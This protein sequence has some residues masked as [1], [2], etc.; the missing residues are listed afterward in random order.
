MQRFIMRFLF[1]FFMVATVFAQQKNHVIQYKL[2]NGL[3]ILVCPEQDASTVAIQLWYNVG[4]KHE[5]DGQRGIAHFI[6][7]MIFKGTEKISESDIDLVCRKLSGDCNAFT[8]CDYTG[9]VFNIPTANWSK[10][11]PIMADCMENCTF[12][13]DHLNSE[14]KA[15]IQELKMNRDAHARDLKSVMITNIFESHPYHYSTIGFKQDLWSVSRQTLLQFY[16]K[17]YTPDNAVIVVVGDIDPQDVYEKVAD[18]FSS[19]PAGNGWN[20]SQFYFNEDAKSKTINL[21][22]D[23]Q[24]ATCDVAFVVPGLM[25]NK[26]FLFEV[27]SSLLANSKTSRLHKKLIDELQLVSNVE[28]FA[29]DM[30]EKGVFFVEFQP[31][32]VEDIAKIT[33]IIQDEFDAIA[34][35]GVAMVEVD[36]A[37]RSI[38]I[39]LQQHLENTKNKAYFIGKYFIANQDPQ[40]LSH[41]DT[42]SSKELAQS[43]QE[44]VQKYCISIVRHEGNVLPVPQSCLQALRQLQQESDEQDRIFLNEKQ[45]SSPV[46]GASYVHDVSVDTKAVAPYPAPEFLQLDNGMDLLWAHNSNSDL[47]EIQLNLQAESFY[48]AQDK[49]GLGLLVARMMQEGT[50][51]YPGQEFMDTIDSYGIILLVNPGSIHMTLLAQDL[52]IGLQ[53]LAE[54][55]QNAEFQEKSFDKIAQQMQTELQQY[56]DTPR[57]FHQYLA[58][59]VVYQEHP[60]SKLELGSQES[61]ASMTLQDC[62]DY[63]RAMISPEQA[64]L[65]LVGNV[66][67]QDVV[68]LVQDAFGAW[69]GPWVEELDYP[70]LMVVQGREILYPINR[71]QTV[72]VFAGLSVDRFHPDY[73]KI[74]LFDQIF[75]GSV[76]S[77]MSSRLFQLRQQSGLFYTISGS[78]M[79]GATDQP[80]MIFIRTIVS[81]DRVEEAQKAILQVIATGIDSL[82]EEELV[83]AKRIVMH[84]FDKNYD[85]N[86]KKTATF[87]FLQK[88]NL[89]F[90]YFERRAQALQDITLEQVQ[91]AVR[92]L[93]SIDNIVVIKIG[94]TGN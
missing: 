52:Q 3:T 80:G 9:Y 39:Q 73:D 63:Y 8:W 18:C 74:L 51:N 60:Y 67:D 64:S 62:T 61:I 14:L 92:S 89:P 15:V 4:S 75:A 24:Q 65:V 71:D 57:S 83:E 77:S 88:Y 91:A 93:I 53:L 35:Q 84:S 66:Q 58:R 94:R 40:A 7:H 22:R 56:W 12:L 79:F 1:V 2:D 90:D 70:Q 36:C 44:L 17:Y 32:K 25:E 16:K 43:I 78:L 11:L 30:F 42:M 29:Y 54:M 34:Q 31:N 46:Q 49:Q 81:C 38:Q 55:M 37:R 23:V 45:R 28:A 76:M 33:A 10:V 27:F 72:L 5:K 20:Q 19:I 86:G 50:K 47:V 85:T 87:S 48:D 21:Y 41:F 26:E 59:T 82:N 6:E 13:Q 68:K 69:Q